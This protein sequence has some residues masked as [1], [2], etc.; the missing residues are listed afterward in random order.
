MIFA[1]FGFGKDAVQTYKEVLL[2]VGMGRVI[3][4]L[5]PGYESSRRDTVGASFS[6]MGSKARLYFGKRK[7]SG[8]VTTS[9]TDSM[10]SPT[11]VSYGSSP[12]FLSMNEKNT[13]SGSS[14]SNRK[15]LPSWAASLLDKK[16][17]KEDRAKDPFVLATYD[18]QAMIE[19]NISAE[20]RSPRHGHEREFSSENVLVRTEVRQG[21]ETVEPVVMGKSVYEGERYT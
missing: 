11:L 12:T 8:S 6:T 4:S 10:R 3:P 5:R 19:S 1:F 18:R 14:S 2:G 15:F 7:H 21:S 20:P 9:A 13:G 16:T 17:C